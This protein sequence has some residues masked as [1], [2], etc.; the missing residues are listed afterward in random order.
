MMW[1]VIA[2]ELGFSTGVLIGASV[3][4]VS[5]AAWWDILRFLLYKPKARRR[6][7]AR[8]C[9][10]RRGGMVCRRANCSTGGGWRERDALVRP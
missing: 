9:R 3:L 6:A 10:R 1:M 7:I 4:L 2:F 5:G 8:R